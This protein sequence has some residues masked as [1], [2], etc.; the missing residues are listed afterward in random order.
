[1]PDDAAKAPRAACGSY[2][3]LIM[4]RLSVV[5]QA[6]LDHKEVRPS[7]DLDPDPQP[8]RRCR[9]VQSRAGLSDPRNKV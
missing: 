1:M 5:L 4:S 9:Q 3:V 6:D 7:P 8:A 2:R